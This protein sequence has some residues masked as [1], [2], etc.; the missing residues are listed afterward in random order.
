MSKYLDALRTAAL[1]VLLAVGGA[2]A[3]SVTGCEREGP[4][5]EAGEKIDDTVEDTG[6]AI[7]DTAE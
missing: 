7:E 5:E 3:I 1:A 2:A 6:E 4:M